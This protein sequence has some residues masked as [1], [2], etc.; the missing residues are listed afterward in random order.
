MP[1]ATGAMTT[2]RSYPVARSALA[3]VRMPPSMKRRS[4][5]VTG[6]QT[7]GTAQLAPT[8][9]TRPASPAASN[10]AN[11]PV[12]ASTAVTLSARAGQVLLYS[13]SSNTF[14]RSA[15]GMVGAASA[16]LPIRARARAGCWLVLTSHSSLP[17]KPQL[18]RTAGSGSGGASWARYSASSSCPEVMSAP[19]TEP[20]EVPMITSAAMRSMP[21]PASPAISPVSQATPVIPPPPRTSARPS[22]TSFIPAEPRRRPRTFG[23][24]S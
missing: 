6:G 8:A 12:R 10:T 13:R 11:S 16:H 21:S 24:F 1:T 23:T 18:I 2:T 9:S 20:A 5:I 7:P 4:P 14:R 17:M 3:M 15:S 19:T 22:M